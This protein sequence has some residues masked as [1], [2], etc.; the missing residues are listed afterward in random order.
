MK[1]AVLRTARFIPA[2]R[3]TTAAEIG[4]ALNIPARHVAYILAML[5]DEEGQSVPSHRMVPKDGKF[6]KPGDWTA[7]QS[8]AVKRLG[9]EGVLFNAAGAIANFGEKLC[10]LPETYVQTR[11]DDEAAS[12]LGE[13][14]ED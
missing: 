4:R 1:W 12:G 7:K 5:T 8:E 6:G 13:L 11:W 3:V 14:F 10:S 2:G 9:T